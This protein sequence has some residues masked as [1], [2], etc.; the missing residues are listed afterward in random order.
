MAN[1]GYTSEGDD[2]EDIYD[3]YGL[4]RKGEVT[5]IGGVATTLKFGAKVVLLPLTAG[6]AVAET[7][8]QLKANRMATNITER[9]KD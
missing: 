1:L 7:V 2:M 9:Y 4:H 6:I 3:S 8:R 5:F